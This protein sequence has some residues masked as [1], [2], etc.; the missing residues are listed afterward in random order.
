M[1]LKPE[2]FSCPDHGGDLTPQVVE[3]LGHEPSVVVG[4]SLA[5]ATAR[6]TAKP[7]PFLV[8]VSCHGGGSPH[9]LECS[10]TFSDD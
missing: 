5:K 7:E 2:H 1:K 4:Y 9:D 3:R 6:R 8:V 10:G